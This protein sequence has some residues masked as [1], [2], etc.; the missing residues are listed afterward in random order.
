MTLLSDA[1]RA[2]ALAQLPGWTL[3]EDGKAIRRTFRFP[4]FRSAFAA[5]TRLA[6]EAEALNHHPD[7]TNVYNR[8]EVQLST[9]D[10]GGLTEKDIAL[11]QAFD[12]HCLPPGAER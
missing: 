2:R 6:F 12:D 3:T 5:M 11:A 1:A 7:W 9:H 4:D 8:L 10:A